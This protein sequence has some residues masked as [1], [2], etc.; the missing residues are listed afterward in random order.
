ME[1]RFPFHSRWSNS[2]CVS[3]L[4]GTRAT[5]GVTLTQALAI[6][7]SFFGFGLLSLAPLPLNYQWVYVSSKLANQV[8]CNWEEWINLETR[9]LGI[10]SAFIQVIKS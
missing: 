10:V 3:R 6:T 2:E 7:Q 1:W 8:I 9:L 5:F 4:G